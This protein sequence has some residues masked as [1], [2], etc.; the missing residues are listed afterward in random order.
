MIKKKIELFSSEQLLLIYINYKF[1]VFVEKIKL[2][3]TFF[4]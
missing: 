4:F 1:Q 3:L 2:L